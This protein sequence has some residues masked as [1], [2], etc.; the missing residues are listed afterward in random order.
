MSTYVAL[1]DGGSREEAIEVT[2]SGPGTYEV[3]IGGAV[4]RVDAFRQDSGTL[5]LIVDT[6]SYC[7]QLDQKDPAVKVHVR[8]SIYPLEILDE[9]RLRLRR[10]AGKL[11]IEGEQTITSPMPGKVVKVLAK[12]GEAVTE[13]QGVVAVEAMEMENELT[14]PK[15][16]TVTAVLVV[17]GQA[18]EGGAKLVVI[19]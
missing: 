6:D 14:S 15:D 17:E 13:G 9:R 11:T 12:A 4:H 16:G 18:V 1:L 7:V 10:G 5:S 3:R 8:G 19:E 2:R